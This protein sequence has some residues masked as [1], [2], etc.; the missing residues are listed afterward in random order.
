MYEAS[1][2]NVISH[3]SAHLAEY[4]AKRG[5][6]LPGP[7]SFYINMFNEGKDLLY[8]HSLYKKGDKIKLSDGSKLDYSTEK[9]KLLNALKS[10]KELFLNKKNT[11][12]KNN[13]SNQQNSD[14]FGNDTSNEN[15]NY[16]RDTFNAMTDGQ[17]GDWDDFDGDID[18][19]MS[20]AGR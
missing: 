4:S 5:I 14:Y 7:K 18:D 19:V 13:Y 2:S 12:S 1:L 15:Y 11:L 16:D 20:W 8:V 6:H 9:S 3:C 17:L 10:N